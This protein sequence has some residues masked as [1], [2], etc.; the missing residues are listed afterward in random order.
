MKKFLVLG[1]NENYSVVPLYLAKWFGKH[2][3]PSVE[4]MCKPGIL[5]HHMTGAT[6]FKRKASAQRAINRT[7]KY[8]ELSCKGKSP[9]QIVRFEIFPLYDVE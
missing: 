9:Y 1:W 5:T 2:E 4:K 6:A 7:I 8:Y 3:N